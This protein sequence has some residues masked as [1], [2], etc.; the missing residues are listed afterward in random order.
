MPDFGGAPDASPGV[1][2]RVPAT[3]A[4][5]GPGFDALGLAL[6]LY[7]EVTAASAD[8]IVISV[9][10][11]GAGEV[12]LDE[13]HLV[14][15]AMKAAF[16]EVGARF[17]GVR[18][19]CANAIPHARGLGS[20]AAAICAGVQTGFA[21][22]GAQ[23]SRQQVYELASRLEGHPDNVAACIFGGATIAWY[24]RKAPR[25]ARLQPCPQLRPVTYVPPVRTSTAAS[26]GT[27]PELVAHGDA[28]ATAARAALLIHGLTSDPAVL[29]DATEDWLHQPYRLAALPTQQTLVEALR[30]AGVPAVLSGSGPTVLAL[31]RTDAEADRALALASDD[32]CAEMLV[33]ERR[34]DEHGVRCVPHG[35]GGERRS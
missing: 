35:T 17:R 19:T 4:N 34:I 30:A 28:A 29:L 18:L 21:L 1:T 9:T 13:S 12:T 24:E 15:E 20:S 5:L 25:A 27:L 6:D 11:E 10:G 7:D 3:S 14:V 16:A 31:A 8:D 2:V 26:R 32:I 33:A 22:A 23:A